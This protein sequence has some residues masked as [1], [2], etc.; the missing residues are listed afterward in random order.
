MIKHNIDIRLGAYLLWN[1][2]AFHCGTY[3]N[4]LKEE[5]RKERYFEESAIGNEF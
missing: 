3:N 5:E 1:F 2:L 4:F